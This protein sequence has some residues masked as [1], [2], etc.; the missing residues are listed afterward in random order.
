MSEEKTNQFALWVLI[1]GGI[2]IAFSPIFVRLSDVGPTASAFWRT[3]LAVPFF[4][5]SMRKDMVQRPHISPQAKRDYRDLMFGGS[6]FAIELAFWHASL[7]YTTVANATLLSNMNP[8]VVALLSVW[9]FKERLGKVF[10]LGLIVGIIGAAFLAGASFSAGGTRLFGDMIGLITATIYGF[11]LVAVSRL[12]KRFSVS[13]VMFW[14]CFM[15]AVLLLPAAYLFGEQI[16]P[17]DSTGWMVL[18]GLALICQILGQ[19]MIT[20]AF[21]HLPAAFGALTLLIQPVVAAAIAWVLFEEY[22][23]AMD[24]FGAALILVGIILARLGTLKKAPAK[25]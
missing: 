3:A 6:L 1:G 12:R 11:Y 8:I 20:Y 13:V 5:W 25:A 2:A 18:I 4:W 23:G 10:F 21:A 14:T 16:L 24:G 22:L 17:N 9:L 19:G 15:S 7:Q